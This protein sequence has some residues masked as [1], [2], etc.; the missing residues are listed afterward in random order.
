MKKHLIL[1]SIITAFAGSASAQEKRET[2]PQ[3][4]E[5]TG[6][7]TT[8][9]GFV[10]STVV[11]PTPTGTG[12][13]AKADVPSAIVSPPSE[14]APVAAVQATPKNE[15][16]PSPQYKAKER[17]LQKNL[18]KAKKHL[19]RSLKHIDAALAKSRKEYA[20]ERTYLLKSVKLADAAH[21]QRMRE[22]DQLE[23]DVMAVY[24]EPL[25]RLDQIMEDNQQVTDAVQKI[26]VD[27]EL[28]LHAVL[29]QISA[30]R[31]AATEQHLVQVDELRQLEKTLTE[32][33]AHIESDL[34]DRRR[35]ARASYNHRKKEY[36]RGLATA[37]K[38][39]W[40]QNH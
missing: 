8:S 27:G 22:F 32:S 28:E 39:Y 3:K 5:P 21:A 2:H 31:R 35:D 17:A 13:I 6:S 25:A 33:Q 14:V 9:T 37:K 16:E 34:A 20:G 38:H 19:T 26:R 29:A 10:A 12:P 30:E 11:V 40:Y 4:L 7:T 1:L 23:L 18:H 36:Q 24:A 15:V